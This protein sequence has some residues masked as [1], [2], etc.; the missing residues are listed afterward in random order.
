MSYELRDWRWIE[1]EVTRDNDRGFRSKEAESKG[2]VRA[3]SDGR[4]YYKIAG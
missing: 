3:Q 2:E 1:I 4:G